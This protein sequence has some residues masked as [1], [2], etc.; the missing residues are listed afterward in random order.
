MT[1]SFHGPFTS[2]DNT[3]QFQN[4]NS[5]ASFRGA[6]R[7][8][9]NFPTQ[10]GF[11]NRDGYNTYPGRYQHAYPQQDQNQSPS[12][13]SAQQNQWN[14]HHQS[15]WNNRG[16]H[17]GNSQFRSQDRGQ[18]QR[19]YHAEDA[20]NTNLHDINRIDK[21]NNANT[22]YSD[23]QGEEHAFFNAK[24]ALLLIDSSSIKSTYYAGD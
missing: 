12:Q 15:L 20:N 4:D 13:P 1:N 22:Y 23:G 19:A 6:F 3:N 10:G 11:Q 16:R 18:W 2:A 7:G 5:Q 9:G 8:R 14:N 17:Q 21:N 24:E